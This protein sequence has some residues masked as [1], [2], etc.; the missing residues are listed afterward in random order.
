MSQRHVRE[1]TKRLRNYYTSF[2][3]TK[4]KSRKRAIDEDPAQ[5][6]AEP[7]NGQ[8][9]TGQQ[10][11]GQ[12]GIGQP[13]PQPG[14]SVPAGGQPIPGVTPTTPPRDPPVDMADYAKRLH[15]LEEKLRERE[16][17]VSPRRSKTARRSTKSRSPSRTS[18]RR[19]KS[20]SAGRSGTHR[21]SRP[22]SGSRHST[23]SSRPRTSGRGYSPS[24]NR[25]RSGR[26][27]SASR[28][29]R[30]RS[31][32]RRRTRTRSPA[33]H[34]SGRR[35]K[36]R[37]RSRSARR[38][39]SRHRSPRRTIS[40]RTLRADQRSA[41]DAE[42][43]LDAQYPAMGTS[44]GNH[45][46]LSRAT[47]EPYRNLPPDIRRRAGERRSRRDLSL[48]EHLCGILLMA[49]KAMDPH[50]EVYG[51]IEHAAQVAQ[52]ATTIQWPTVRTWSQACLAHL[53]GSGASWHDAH[54]FKDERM[55]L[56]WCKGK[57]QPDVMIPCPQFNTDICSE[58]RNHSSEGRT[59]LHTC[60]V[61]YYGINDTKNDHTS[62]RCRK[63]P[64]LKLV[65]EEGRH[66]NNNRRRFNYNNNNNNSQKRDE[67]QDRPK[68]KN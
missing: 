64:G 50:S 11:D 1:S 30:T 57:S 39:A 27:R 46:H 18:G 16:A 28:R 36:S 22:R 7:A 37:S 5:I 13:G 24:S 31:S 44:Q 26:R 43:A 53:E 21:S 29:R 20:P 23:R 62:Q 60:G 32:S 49:L 67:K 33:R 41:K 59:W 8:P 19:T 58:K 6:M 48:P 12:P 25:S 54:I 63:K 40:P 55:R 56:C 34:S 51:A 45:L 42:R 68:P 15:A 17:R 61:C 10:G 65:S 52:D 14:T 9:G 35:S 4:S 2:P 66:E 38:S 3:R 47:L